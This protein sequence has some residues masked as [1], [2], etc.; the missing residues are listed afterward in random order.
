MTTAT[1]YIYVLCIFSIFVFKHLHTL[2]GLKM[3][4]EQQAD[5]RR[6]F[7]C[8]EPGEKGAEFRYMNGRSVGGERRVSGL[9]VSSHQKQLLEV[10]SDLG[11]NHDI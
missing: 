5:D 7:V 10:V 2:T 11:Y 4:F 8:W 3:G 1:S 6:H 9:G